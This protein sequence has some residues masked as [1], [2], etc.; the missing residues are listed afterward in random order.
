MLILGDS[1]ST[2]IRGSDVLYA[3][4]FEQPCV[5]TRQVHHTHDAYM[6]DELKIP[7]S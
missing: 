4:P 2:L 1:S 5:S 6:S 3:D 7:L